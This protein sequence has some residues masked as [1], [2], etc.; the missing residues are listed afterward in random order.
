[1]SWT[2]IS[3]VTITW[4]IADVERDTGLSKD[5]L[6]VWERRYGF[7]RPR[8]DAF[9][10]RSYTAAQVDK[11]RVV[12]RLLDAGYRPGGL[13]SR[14][15]GELRGLAGDDSSVRDAP[16]A[17]ELRD[18]LA[19]LRGN[20]AG[21]LRERLALA[22][23][24]LGLRSV[25]LDIVAPLTRF[26]GEAWMRGELRIYEEHLF[27]ECVETVLRGKL[28]GLLSQPGGARVLLATTPGEPHGLGLLMAQAVL[29]LEGCTCLSLGVQVPL[30]DIVAAAA[31]CR[32][33]I[34]ALSV[35]GCQKRSAA[36]GS[37]EQ[38]RRRL[39]VRIALWVGGSAPAL[40][41]FA[42]DGVTRVPTLEAIGAALRLASRPPVAVAAADG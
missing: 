21:A 18:W 34:V 32:A 12:K 7:P 3:I 17:D 29:A 20:E 37:I 24:R 15:M 14:P 11:L 40:R 36:I 5:T 8:R 38:L 9:G 10:E 13:V 19:L 39:P 1:L 16:P 4:S 22:E 33:D 26:V 28:G 41:R 6:R 2:K 31:D 35:S 42:L 27:T 25:V 30:D 23:G